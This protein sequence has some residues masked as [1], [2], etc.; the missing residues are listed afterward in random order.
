M[1]TRYPPVTLRNSNERMLAQIP[2][3]P[4]GATSHAGVK[5]EP[6]DT[7]SVSASASASAANVLRDLSKGRKKRK[8]QNAPAP[9][10]ASDASQSLPKSDRKRIAR[11]AQRARRAARKAQERETQKA[12]AQK[13]QAQKTEAIT[14]TKVTQT[15]SASVRANLIPLANRRLPEVEVPEPKVEKRWPF[16]PKAL[17]AH[18]ARLQSRTE[19]LQGMF[20]PM[21]TLSF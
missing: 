18:L 20:P 21:T 13:A 2:R 9:V 6:D 19:R 10:S 8:T 7:T 1:I 15:Q 17:G 12:L 5:R 4:G 16:S 14:C 3:V 11:R